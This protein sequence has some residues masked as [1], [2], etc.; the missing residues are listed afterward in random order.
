MPKVSIGLP[1]YNGEQFIR[2]AIDSVLK[3]TFLD[4]ELIVSDNASTD[5]TQD[6]VEFYV[7]RDRRIRYYRNDRNFG[8]AYN[9]NR[10]VELAQGKYFK[11]LSHDDEIA[12][13]YLARCVETLDQNHDAVLCYPKTV[14]IDE[15]GTKISKHT[16]GVD[17]RASSPRMRFRKFLRKPAGCNP[18]FGLMRKE[19][20]SSSNLIGSYESSDYIMLAEMCLKGKVLEI[21]EPLF[22]RR[23]HPGMSR[24]KNR[25]GRELINWFD[26]NHSTFN[27]FPIVR[28]LVELIKAVKNS[29]ISWNDRLLCYIEGLM[30]APVLLHRALNWTFARSNHRRMY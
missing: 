19:V 22:F 25:K 12:P 17:L 3:Q 28:L 4:Y 14:I 5:S 23:N 6:I 18:V 16:D 15:E 30:A 11:W 27:T 20:L 10:I 21:P 26:T 1:V 2:S 29:D 7:N 9:Y 8:A 13:T 24:R